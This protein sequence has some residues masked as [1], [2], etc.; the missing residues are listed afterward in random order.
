MINIIFISI[1]IILLIFLIF[2][3]LSNKKLKETIVQIK[4]MPP[5]QTSFDPLIASG[6]GL[7]VIN[8]FIKL[9]FLKFINSKLITINEESDSPITEFLTQLSSDDKM[10]DFA[11]GFVVYIEA[12]MS[13]E[14][15]SYFNKFFNILDPST[16]ETNNLFVEYITEW[17]ILFIRELQLELSS[18]KMGSEDYSIETNIRQNSEIFIG[19]ELDLY[20][21]FRIIDAVPEASKK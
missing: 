12:M 14:L 8:D 10:K 17:I 3:L 6:K 11:S 21:S 2:I 18:K 1:L 9:N 13:K 4:N 7:D 15:K 20:K 16:G 5:T 19:L